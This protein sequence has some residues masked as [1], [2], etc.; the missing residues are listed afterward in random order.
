M[1]VLNEK[2]NDSKGKIKYVKFDKYNMITALNGFLYQNNKQSILIEG[3]AKT[4]DSFIKEGNW[5]EAN[6]LIGNKK[7]N[8]GT[9]APKINSSP[10]SIIKHGEDKIINFR[11]D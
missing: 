11:N 5:N 9:S 1:V 4:I 7:F 8:E 3:G 10:S 6:V 2:I